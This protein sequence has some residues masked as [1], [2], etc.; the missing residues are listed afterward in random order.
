M[1]SL[2][3]LLYFAKIKWKYS[4]LFNALHGLSGNFASADQF[5]V[6]QRGPHGRELKKKQT[7]VRLNDGVV[8][9]E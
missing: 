1:W 9:Q 2:A 6:A 4:Y 3:H 5:S 8:L 7:K